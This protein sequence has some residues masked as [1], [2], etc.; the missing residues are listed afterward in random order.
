MLD[1]LE[2]DLLGDLARDDHSLHEFFGFVRLHH[3]DLDDARV[4]ETGRALI[5][6]WVARGWLELSSDQ[7]TWGDAKAVDDLLPILDRH[8]TNAMRFFDGS[9]ALRLGENSYAEVDWLHC[10]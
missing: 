4:F 5:A 7:S 1:T 10:F 8:G 3:P 2:E 6:E 9:P